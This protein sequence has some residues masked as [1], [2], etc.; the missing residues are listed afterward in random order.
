MFIKIIPKIHPCDFKFLG[1]IFTWS[2][3]TNNSHILHTI[4]IINNLN[5]IRFIYCGNIELKNLQGPDVLKLLIAVDELNIQQLIP[6]VQEFL[7][8]HK[9]EFYTKIRLVFLNPFI[10][11]KHLQ[12]YGIF[13]LKL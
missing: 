10:S 13:V 3:Y 5:W 12:I 7:I 4:V 8:E 2:S 1:T 6:H 11:M 9:T